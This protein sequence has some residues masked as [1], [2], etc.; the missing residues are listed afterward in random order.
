MT[1]RYFLT[2]KHKKNIC[3]LSYKFKVHVHVLNMYAKKPRLHS[4]A[5]AFHQGR[6]GQSHCEAV[7]TAQLGLAYFSRAWL[8]SQPQAGPEEH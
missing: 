6:L 4:L 1:R 3:I 7:I 2:F 8:G 5:L